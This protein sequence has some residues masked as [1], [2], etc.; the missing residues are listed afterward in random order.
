MERTSPIY[1]L[2]LGGGTLEETEQSIREAIE[3]TSKSCAS[4]AN[5]SP[6]QPRRTG[7]RSS[8]P[9]VRRYVFSNSI[10]RSTISRSVAL[11]SVAETKVLRNRRAGQ[12]LL[13]SALLPDSRRMLLAG[14]AHQFVHA[15]GILARGC[16]HKCATRCGKYRCIKCGLHACANSHAE[17]KG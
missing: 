8:C 10:T 6:S 13:R 11:G 16:Q 7:H 17:R 4:T 1:R 12:S 2:H 15:P 9:G 14:T 5:L 3:A